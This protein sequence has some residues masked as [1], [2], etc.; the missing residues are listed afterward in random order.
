MNLPTDPNEGEKGSTLDGSG[1]MDWHSAVAWGMSNVA[2]GE[3]LVSMSSTGV[4]S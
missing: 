4:R 2:P 1:V 3:S